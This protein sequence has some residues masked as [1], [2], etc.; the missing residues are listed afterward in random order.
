VV[1]RQSTPAIG[2]IN[3]EEVAAST[4]EVAAIVGN[5]LVLAV[6]MMGFAALNPSYSLA[7]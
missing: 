5:C 1:G 6:R 7:A 2:Q 3:S 4:E